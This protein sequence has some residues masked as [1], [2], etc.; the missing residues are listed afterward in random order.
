[1]T[2]K[3]LNNPN[4]FGWQ[5]SAK[6][7][8]AFI[9]KDIN[10]DGKIDAQDRTIIGNPHPNLIFGFDNVFK[11]KNLSLSILLT[12][13]FG[14][15]IGSRRL[16]WLYNEK[17]RWNVS[18]KF[19]HRWRSFDDP[20]NGIIPAIFYSGQHAFNN[21]LVESGNHIWVKNI[22]LGYTIPHH[23]LNQLKLLSNIRVY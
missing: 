7:P 22:T 20:G 13:A 1:E 18:T 21:V 3:Q 17:G 15:Q 5:P 6:A 23:L 14:Y 16:G 8:G 11:Y 12:G 2:Q 10:G 9:F 4:L 19:L